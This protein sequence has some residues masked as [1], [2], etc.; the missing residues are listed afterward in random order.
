[1]RGNIQRISRWCAGVRAQR[2][3]DTDPSL[4]AI[5][6]P[7]IPNGLTFPTVQ[8]LHVLCGPLPPAC[9]RALRVSVILKPHLPLKDL[10]HLVLV[11]DEA[12][13]VV[14]Q[15]SYDAQA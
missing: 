1:M 10:S 13:M 14:P 8:T 6:Y 5:L 11:E 9:M 3:L 15:D 7:P 4:L 2:P 12:G